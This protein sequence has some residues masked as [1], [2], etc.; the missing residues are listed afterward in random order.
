MTQLAPLQFT[1]L[2]TSALNA[3]APGSNALNPLFSHISAYINTISL[4]KN[5]TYTPVN[6]TV[7]TNTILYSNP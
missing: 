2:K 7:L 5:I 6:P 3:N 1:P 4:A